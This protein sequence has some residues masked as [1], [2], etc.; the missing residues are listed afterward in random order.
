MIVYI[1][2]QV[3]EDVDNFQ[4]IILLFSLIMADENSI[5][6]DYSELE[7]KIYFN[8]YPDYI[9]S[10]IELSFNEAI[11]KIDEDLTFG[12]RINVQSDEEDFDLSESIRYFQQAVSIVLENNNYDEYFLRAIFKYYRRDSNKILN[13]LR[14]GRMI[15]ENGGGKDN[16]RVFIEGRKRSFTHLP[17]APYRYLRFFVL[18][19]S[20]KLHPN[21]IKNE[22]LK[23]Y[24]VDNNIIFHELEK[25]EMENYLPNEV[26]QEIN[27]DYCQR[28]LKL[29]NI[30][31]DFFDIQNGWFNKKFENLCQDIQ[32]LY[33]D[34]SLEDRLFFKG[35]KFICRNF[36]SEFARNFEKDIV[37]KESLLN[38]IRHQQNNREFVDI[39]N[40]IKSI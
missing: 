13:L 36:K 14:N 18:F 10:Y 5:L 29:S 2:H 8:N 38:R 3:F 39:I 12:M 11:T 19:D 4:N 25:R 27:D 6:C 15:I 35:N 32:N 33:S 28:Y 34:V 22:N 30:Q 26:F 1:E 17:K 24:L 21:H 40:K 37:T 9:K 16:M 20:D 7:N 23:Q 31:K